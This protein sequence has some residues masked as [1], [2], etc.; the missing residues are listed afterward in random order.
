MVNVMKRAGI[1]FG[2]LGS[3]FPENR[4]HRRDTAE[5]HRLAE[6]LDAGAVSLWI[7]W[8]FLLECLPVA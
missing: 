4:S 7:L 3:P 5:P 2:C 6:T 8:D 1:R